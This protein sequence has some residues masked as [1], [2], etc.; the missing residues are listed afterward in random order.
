MSRSTVRTAPSTT[1]PPTITTDGSTRTARS[2]P[3]RSDS[4]PTSGKAI[5]SPARWMNRRYAPATVALIR[6]GTTSKITARHRPVVPRQDRRTRRAKTGLKQVGIPDGEQPDRQR[7]AE[8]QARAPPSSTRA[9]SKSAPQPVRQHAAEQRARRPRD[10]PPLPQQTTPPPPRSARAP[11]RRTSAPSPR[12]RSVPNEIMAPA[13]KTY[14]R[15]GVCSTVR[16]ARTMS[17][18]APSIAADSRLPRPGRRA[19]GAPSAGW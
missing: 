9:V 7:P 13:E 2:S 15:V 12:C 14:T 10:Q 4:V 3:N 11:A 17:A 6:P 1:T 8:Q 18:N 16:P 5:A 19:S